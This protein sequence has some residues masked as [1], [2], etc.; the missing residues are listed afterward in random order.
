MEDRMDEEGDQDYTGDGS[1]DEDDTN[2]M[3]YV[4]KK[5]KKKVEPSME[6]VQLWGQYRK[7]T[8]DFRPDDWRTMGGLPNVKSYTEHP[9]AAMFKAPKVDPQAPTL[10]TK[11]LVFCNIFE[12]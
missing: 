1:D 12:F 6:T 2:L 9:A 10:K 11:R 4:H 5:V 7:K 3:D 8:T